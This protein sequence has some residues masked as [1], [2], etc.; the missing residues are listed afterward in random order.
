MRLFYRFSCI[1]RLGMLLPTIATIR[2]VGDSPYRR[3]E[4][5]TTPRN[6]DCDNVL[7]FPICLHVVTNYHHK[8]IKTAPWLNVLVKIGTRKGIFYFVS[9]KLLNF[10][11]LWMEET[12]R[13]S[14]SEES[15]NRTPIKFKI[16]LS[17]LGYCP[18]LRAEINL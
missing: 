4:E 9:V 5:W 14:V 6:N 10:S 13:G 15:Y 2:G 11:H 16:T 7:K 1:F 12:A 17:M 3:Y 8:M 18:I